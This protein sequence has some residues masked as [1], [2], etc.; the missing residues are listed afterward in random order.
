[1]IELF[2]YLYILYVLLSINKLLS[3]LAYKCR[4]QVDSLFLDCLSDLILS[5]YTRINTVQW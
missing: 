3:A 1:M 5:A 4:R 2:N